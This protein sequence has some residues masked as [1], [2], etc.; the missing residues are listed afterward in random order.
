MRRYYIAYG[1]NLNLLQMAKRCRGARIIGTSYLQD[2][3]LLFKG[4]GSGYYLTVEKKEGS[5]VPVVV[6]SV[7]KSDEDALDQYEGYPLFYYKETFDLS[8]KPIL[9]EGEIRVTGF[10]YLMHVDRK[11]GLPSRRYMDTCLAGYHDFGFNVGVL[12]KAVE[13]SREAMT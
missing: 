11:P 9:G 4:S 5:T 8:V 6:Y 7:T 13:D 12:W 2:F 10:A 3:Q 1:S